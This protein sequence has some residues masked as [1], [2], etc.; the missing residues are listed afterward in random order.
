MDGDNDGL[1]NGMANLTGESV[2]SAYAFLQGD[3]FVGFYVGC[4][5]DF[6]VQVFNLWSG[7]LDG[8]FAP[9][10]SK[11]IQ[12]QFQPGLPYRLYRCIGSLGHCIGGLFP[13]DESVGKDQDFSVFEDVHAVV[14][15]APAT[16]GHPHILRRRPWTSIW[17]KM[18]ARE[19]V[20][21][22]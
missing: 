16:G 5:L 8:F 22:I 11:L 9:V 19:R 12:H 14:H 13:A 1:L 2:G 17:K 6:K 10:V 7:C 15:D 21:S 20:T 18:V 4:T 3:V